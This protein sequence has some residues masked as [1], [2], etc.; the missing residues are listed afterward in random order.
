MDIVDDVKQIVANSLKI[1]IEQLKGTST[2]KDIGAE[3]IDV[4]EIVYGLEEKFDVDISTAFKD[5]KPSGAAGAGG[6]ELAALGD[7]TIADVA[8][9]VQK[10]ID[11][12]GG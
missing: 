12:K 7:M 9:A 1:P 10:L 4:I 6:N 8:K 2:L 3:S 11:T 5:S